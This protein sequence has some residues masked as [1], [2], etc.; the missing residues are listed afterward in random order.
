[1]KKRSKMYY[2]LNIKYIDDPKKK[3]YFDCT[4]GA[5]KEYGFDAIALNITSTGRIP[6]NPC[7]IPKFPAE[8]GLHQYNRL[9]IIIDDP[10]QNYGLN[11]K[12]TILQSYDIIAVEPKNEKVFQMAC[13][14]MEIDLI[15]FD[16]TTE[17]L[18][19]QLKHGLVREAISRGVYFEICLGAAL[20]NDLDLRKNVLANAMA[21]TRITK[22]KNTIVTSGASSPTQLRGPFDIFNLAKLVGIPSH[23]AMSSIKGCSALLMERVA[24]RKFTHNGASFERPTTELIAKQS[25]DLLKD[26]DIFVS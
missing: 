3:S 8:I 26:F 7:P 11:S 18:P 16:L 24:T 25:S 6:K 10:Q 1:M 17:R 22:G 4:L 15:T 21:V 5:L 14:S 2:D 23:L 19:Y 12:N 13:Q 20:T 9:T